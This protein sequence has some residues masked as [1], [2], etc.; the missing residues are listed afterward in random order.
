MGEETK[1]VGWLAA[2]VLVS[3]KRGNNFEKKRA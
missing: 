1:K 2:S 3:P